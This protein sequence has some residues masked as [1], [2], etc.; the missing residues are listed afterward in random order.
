MST[1]ALTKWLIRLQIRYGSVGKKDYHILELT[2]LK[3]LNFQKEIKV[4]D[5]VKD[6]WAPPHTEP[7]IPPLLTM[8]GVQSP[9]DLV[10]IRKYGSI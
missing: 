1:M 6:M 8:P 5:D 9:N 4:P 3:N 2:S 10:N 7:G